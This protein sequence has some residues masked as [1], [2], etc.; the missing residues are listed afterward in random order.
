M[1]YLR[2]KL[3]HMYDRQTDDKEAQDLLADILEI[4]I[5]LWNEGTFCCTIL[6]VLS[7]H[8]LSDIIRIPDMSP[9]KDG[10]ALIIAYDGTV[11]CTVADD[12]EWQKICK[13]GDHRCEE[14][15]AA[16]PKKHG[17]SRKRPCMEMTSSG[18]NQEQLDELS[19]PDLPWS[20]VTNCLP[21]YLSMHAC[22]L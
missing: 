20:H 5:K 1:P 12:P 17:P 7:A 13:E 15:A 4:E 9:T 14:A 21:F 18:N 16:R 22:T 11:L 19:L 8:M 6:F 10:M 2:R 3:G